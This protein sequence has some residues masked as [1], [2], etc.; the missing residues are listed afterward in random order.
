MI[1]IVTTHPDNEELEWTGAVNGKDAQ[2]F[3]KGTV[4]L[5]VDVFP[6]DGNDGSTLIRHADQALYRAKESGRIKVC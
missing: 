3:G 1:W 4:S 6:E 5:A 2:P